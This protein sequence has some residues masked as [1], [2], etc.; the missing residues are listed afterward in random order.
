MPDTPRIVPVEDVQSA[1]L[2]APP[3]PMRT[4][5]IEWTR[6]AA[7]SDARYHRLSEVQQKVILE[8]IIT[9]STAVRHH[10]KLATES[11]EPAGSGVCVTSGG[12][13]GILTARHVLYADDEGKKRLPNPVI[14]FMPPKSAMLRELKR[15]DR[16]LDSKGPLGVF[17]MVGISIGNRETVV[18]LQR[19]G[20]SCPDPGLP[21]IAVIAISNDIEE[22]LR[23]TA[24]AEGRVAP[25]PEWLDL[26]AEE[27]VGIPYSMTNND[28]DEMLEGDWIITG[29]RGERSSIG[30]ILSESNV[31]IVD[32]IY[33][34]SEYEYYGIFLDEVNG[35]RARSK[36]WKGT[37]GGGVWQQRFTQAGRRKL[38][39]IAPSPLTP[40]DLEPPVLGGI[41]FFH[42]TRKSPQ[43]LRSADGTCHRSEL[44]AHRIDE[45]L[46][47]IIRRALRHGVGMADNV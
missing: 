17:P 42:E 32:R 16:P 22:R 4:D 44:Y 38:Q 30:K 29:V 39:S 6:R 8:G 9:Y 11:G 28:T 43:E 34:R 19:P 12:R 33:R 47:G 31:G 25:E 41:A 26:D 27:Q 1:I 45:M 37:S 20:K 46:L 40:E 3:L 18:P 2:G 13:L 36:G 21:D 10:A 7:L 24:A 14:S 23:E 15:H 5:E 35:S